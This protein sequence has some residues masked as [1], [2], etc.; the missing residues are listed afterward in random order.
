[1]AFLQR[2]LNG[3]GRIEREYAAGR[4]RI[5]LAI[6]W[7]GRWT[8]IEIKLVSEK[9]GRDST[10]EKG[11]RQVARYRATVGAVEA[12]LILFDRRPAARAKPWEER[13]TW[14]QHPDPTNPAAA[15]ITVVGA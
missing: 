7:Q 4:E 5:D 2:I 15:P 13:L 14:E 1:M 12:W 8:V 6:E 3:K 10:L 11:L 9:R